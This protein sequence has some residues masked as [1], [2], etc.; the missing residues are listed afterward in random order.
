M[1]NQYNFNFKKSEPMPSCPLRKLDKN[2][3]PFFFFFLFGKKNKI[4]TSIDLMI[5]PQLCLESG[6]FV[7][8]FSFS[9]FVL[10]VQ[11]LLDHHEFTEELEHAWNSSLP[12]NLRIKSLWQLL[13]IKIVNM[14]TWLGAENPTLRFQVS[15]GARK[16]RMPR[17]FGLWNG[18]ALKSLGF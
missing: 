16:E 5:L 1:E 3:W 18:N 7:H 15:C 11:N 9:I 8:H 4:K 17:N 10:L 13:V 12:G 2:S 6:S 14:F